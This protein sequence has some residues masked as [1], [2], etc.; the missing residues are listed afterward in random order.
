MDETA[1]PRDVGV[2][3]IA[4]DKSEDAQAELREKVIT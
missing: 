3:H 1:G 2:N 4:L